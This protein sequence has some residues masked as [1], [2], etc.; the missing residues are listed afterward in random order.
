MSGY[1]KRFDFDD[2]SRQVI[3]CA[4]DVHRELGPGFMERCYKNAMRIALLSA[5]LD[6]VSETT[7]SVRYRGSEV[8]SHQ[9]DL[10]VKNQLVLELKAVKALTEVHF[11]QL[12][13]YLRAGDFRIGLLLSFNA[14]K[15]E[16]RRLVNRYHDIPLLLK[17]R[18]SME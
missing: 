12:R 7:A 15:L 4:I 5:G 17:D 2:L 1:L 14:P 11:A 18:P 13:S 10:V 6:C 9:F 8:G 16:V 3:G